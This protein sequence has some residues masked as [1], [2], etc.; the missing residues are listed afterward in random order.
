MSLSSL[1]DNMTGDQPTKDWE[2][3][4]K[5]DRFPSSD[6]W[7]NGLVGEFLVEFSNAVPELHDS[8]RLVPEAVL[9]VM[10][11]T[12]QEYTKKISVALELESFTGVQSLEE[13][14]ARGMDALTLCL[15]PMISG[16]LA[17]QFLYKRDLMPPKIQ[18]HHFKARLAEHLDR[19]LETVISP[20]LDGILSMIHET[21]MLPQFKK[22]T[23]LRAF[24]EKRP[25]AEESVSTVL[26]LGMAN[27]ACMWFVA[28]SVRSAV[29]PTTMALAKVFLSYSSADKRRILRI[30][31][32]LN[33]QGIETWRDEKNIVAGSPILD[34]VR[35]GIAQE[36]DLTVLFMSERSLQ[37]KW[38]ETEI[39][40]AYQRE[41]ELGKTVLIPVLLDNCAIP[42]ELNV[43][44]YVDARTGLK[45]PV[46]EIASAIKW[47][48]SRADK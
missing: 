3:N 15:W 45:R 18:L 25:G 4:W 30:E 14:T 35:D 9:A 38:V 5:D 17:T 39:R 2:I 41:I 31:R 20:R 27:G 46:D 23:F 43:K 6:P 37:S 1:G 11:Q 33:K 16:Y 34:S 7:E 10:L 32:Q 29:D 44:K 36:T 13:G 19:P 8:L 22:N 12:A 21:I 28:D 48:A 24:F 40:M 47:H 26:S 42:K